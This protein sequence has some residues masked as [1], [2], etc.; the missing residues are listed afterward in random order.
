VFLQT[1]YDIFVQPSAAFPGTVDAD[2]EPCYDDE[3]ASRILSAGG[4]ACVA[5]LEYVIRLCLR[6]CKYQATGTLIL[7]LKSSEDHCVF[8]EIADAAKTDKLSAVMFALSREG[9]DH[10]VPPG[11]GEVDDHGVPPERFVLSYAVDV[12]ESPHDF[13]L[14]CVSSEGVFIR[15]LVDICEEMWSIHSLQCDELEDVGR[16]VITGRSFVD[17]DEL[18][19]KETDRLAKLTVMKLIRAR[20]ARAR[21]RVKPKQGKRKRRRGGAR[22]DANNMSCMHMLIS[23]AGTC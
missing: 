8:V 11:D 23:F 15:T 13:A 9:D 22:F 5:G 12:N 2:D 4:E 7:E 3:C 1:D 6:H 21:G 14:P 16:M 20:R 19:E 10:G 17:R 18:A